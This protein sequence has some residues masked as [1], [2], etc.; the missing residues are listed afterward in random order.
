[1]APRPSC[2]SS[3]RPFAGRDADPTGALATKYGA[4]PAPASKLRTLLD[5][6]FAAHSFFGSPILQGP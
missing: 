1:M 6:R 4:Q 3:A 2:P 5:T